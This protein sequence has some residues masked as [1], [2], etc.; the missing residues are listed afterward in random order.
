MGRS[1][2]CIAEPTR[3][4]PYFNQWILLQEE[5]RM[6]DKSIQGSERVNGIEKVRKFYCKP[7]FF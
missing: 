5:E 3:I 1:T 4:R 6:I 2:L 7:K